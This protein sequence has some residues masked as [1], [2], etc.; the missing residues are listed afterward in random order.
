LVPAG[1]LVFCAVNP[2]LWHH[3]IDAFRTHFDLNTHRTLNVPIAFLGRVYDL[4]HTLPWYNTIVWLVF[5]TPVPI[6]ILG[7]VGLVHCLRTRDFLSASLVLNW[8]TLMVVRAFPGAPPHDGVRL[9]LPAFGFWC[10][11]AGIGAH[12][13]W[14]WSRRQSLA[15]RGVLVRATIVVAL[16]ADA[17]NVARYFPQTLS[18][19]SLLVGGVRGAA[20]LGM[21]PTYWWDALDGD[22]LTWLNGHTGPGERIAFSSTANISLLR[23]WGRLQM[24]QAPRDGVFKWYVLQN[25]TAFLAPSDHRLMQTA[26]PAY[27][28]F[29]GHHPAGSRVPADLNVPLLLVFSYDQYKAAGRAGQ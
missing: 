12:H 23:S 10:V 17:V 15:R 19:Y 11:F 25:R 7:A 5:V 24:V 29:A 13:A 20:S 21:E 14:E 9:F 22:V 6:L 27:A 16:A 3:P 1:L 18:H 28:K 4:D 26:T 8:A 2:P